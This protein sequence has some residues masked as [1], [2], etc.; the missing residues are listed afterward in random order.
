MVTYNDEMTEATVTF[1]NYI[2]RDLT[3][4]NSPS[5]VFTNLVGE[6]PG[7]WNATYANLDSLLNLDPADD[8]DQF[9][10]VVLRYNNQRFCWDIVKD[11]TKDFIL[12][13]LTG[14]EVRMNAD[15]RQ[16]PKQTKQ[17]KK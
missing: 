12:K 16:A 11:E 15:I 17:T 2:T 14:H 9:G 5:Q 6:Q 10:E 7:F 8:A 13:L 1:R 3:S 4:S